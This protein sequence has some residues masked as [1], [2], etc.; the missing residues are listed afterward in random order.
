MNMAILNITYNGLAMDYAIDVDY[1]LSDR[2]IRRVAVEVIRSGGIKGLHI[3]AL[4]ERTFDHYVIDRFVSP[5]GDRRVYLRPKV[6]FGG[7]AAGR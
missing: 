5:T 4:P 7:H 3:A 2:D 1:E 6:P